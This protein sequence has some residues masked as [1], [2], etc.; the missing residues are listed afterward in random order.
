MLESKIIEWEKKNNAF[1]F[2]K[3]CS[4]ETIKKFY[5]SGRHIKNVI[6]K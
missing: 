2:S 6:K 4:I 1:I 5:L 3:A